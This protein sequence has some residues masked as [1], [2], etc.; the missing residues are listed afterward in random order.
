MSAKYYVRSWIS[1]I[2]LFVGIIT[3]VIVVIMASK[4]DS[5][6]APKTSITLSLMSGIPQGIGW[7]LAPFNDIWAGT[8][9][10]S[11]VWSLG[12]ATSAY[13]ML[14]YGPYVGMADII[15]WGIILI[16]T[17]IIANKKNA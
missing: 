11:F 17:Q 2:C 12:I 10:T 7:A 8:K 3:Y 13:L 14:N 5:I 9:S 6:F 1:G 15:A 4:G 16:I